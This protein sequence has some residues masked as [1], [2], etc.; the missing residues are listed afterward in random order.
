VQELRNTGGLLT[1]EAEQ[2]VFRFDHAGIGAALC[3]HWNLPASIAN[4]VGGHHLSAGPASEAPMDPLAEVVHLADALAHG[5]NL[6]ADPLAAVPPVSDAAW[7]R[8]AGKQDQMT[9]DIGEIKTLYQELVVLV[10]SS[11]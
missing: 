8:F 10:D 11:G 2:R 1:S 6:E 7:V 4:A 5:L 3:R 9:R